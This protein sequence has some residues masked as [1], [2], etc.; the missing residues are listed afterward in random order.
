MVPSF[1]LTLKR[2]MEAHN[3]LK[4][5]QF[6]MSSTEVQPG[7]HTLSEHFTPTEKH[8]KPDYSI[9][10]IIRAENIHRVSNE[11]MDRVST[12]FA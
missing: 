1:G 4:L 9:G 8:L 10:S 5:D 12:V 11:R 7:Q 6:V 2:S 3:Y